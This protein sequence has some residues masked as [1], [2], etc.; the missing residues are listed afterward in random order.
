[1]K[2]NWILVLVILINLNC[3]KNKTNKFLQQEDISLVQ[4]RIEVSNTIID[5]VV[6]LYAKSGI[7]GTDIYFT[8][9]GSEPA[10]S[11]FKYDKPIMVSKSGTYKFKS[12]NAEWKSSETTSITFFK[13][14]HQ[15]KN[16]VWNSKQNEKYNGKGP[17]TLINQKKAALPFSN[18]EWVG[19]DS[20]VNAEVFFNEK[21]FIK[22]MDIGFLSDV[23]SWI[24]PPT[25]I[26]IFPNKSNKIEDK[27]SFQLDE[28]EKPELTEM[29]NI[30]IEINKEVTS[31]RLEITNLQSIPTWHEGSG[32]KA[33]LFMDEWIFN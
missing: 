18:S 4:P 13:K 6:S 7:K 3:K 10:S 9:D 28:L 30:N 8:S 21:T 31:L 5:S 23:Q 22:S 33:W 27:I 11:S 14:G 25:S 17:F 26:T 2:K 24:F 20:I 12:F 19:F 16:I 1:M 29:K 32:N 15:P